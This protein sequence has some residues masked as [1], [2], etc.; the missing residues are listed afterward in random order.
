MKNLSSQLKETESDSSSGKD[1]SSDKDKIM[2]IDFASWKTWAIMLG[3]EVLWL[4]WLEWQYPSIESPDSE[5]RKE[6][7]SL[8]G[9]EDLD[10]DF[11]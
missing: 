1:N 4:L 8:P 3:I 2:S 11:E 7:Y 9:M 6:D 10:D 5:E